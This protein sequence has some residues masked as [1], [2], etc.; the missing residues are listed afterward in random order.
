MIWAERDGMK[1]ER[2]EREVVRMAER[3]P[4]RDEERRSGGIVRER[5]LE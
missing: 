5:S 2:D 4:A 3:G 1:E